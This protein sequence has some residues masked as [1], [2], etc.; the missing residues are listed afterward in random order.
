MANLSSSK[1]KMRKDV[2]R[3]KANAVYRSKIDRALNLAKRV[4]NT[5]EKPDIAGAYKLIDKA[6][7]RGILSKQRASKLKSRVASK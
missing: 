3:T 1:K 4:N 5:N 7:K 2:K 6:A